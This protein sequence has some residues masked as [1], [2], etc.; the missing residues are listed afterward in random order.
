MI[1]ASDADVPKFAYQD[2]NSHAFFATNGFAIYTEVFDSYEIE[3]LSELIYSAYTYLISLN[4]STNSDFDNQG[5]AIAIMD[6]LTKTNLWEKLIS[7]VNLLDLMSAILGPDIALLGYDALW[8][9]VPKDT[10]PVLSKG[11]HTDAWTGTSI[12][13]IFAKFFIT[14]VDV[15]N[16]LAVAPGSHTFGMLPTRNREIDP[17]IN[18]EFDM[19]NIDTVN[20]GDIVIWHPLLIHST[21]G[22]SDKNIRISITSRFTSTETPFSSQERAL[23]YRTLRVGV[24]NQILRLVGNDYLTPLRTYGGFIGIDRRM[25][26]VYYSGNYPPHE[27][28]SEQIR[29][30]FDG[31]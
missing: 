8:I 7:N 14:D 4:Q 22:H 18:I 6:E 3:K 29:S 30:L 12:N 9:N 28:Y 15:H 23:G 31:K 13:T 17:Q 1:L 11:Q 5:F 19:L 16:G 25:S 21:V 24:M 27:N 2:R 10:N 20:A 26:E